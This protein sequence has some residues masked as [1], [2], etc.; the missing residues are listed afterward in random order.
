MSR[1]VCRM[2][3]ALFASA[4]PPEGKDGSNQQAMGVTLMAFLL[5]ADG[6]SEVGYP[7]GK[8]VPEVDG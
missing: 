4:A 3:M 2:L 7:S 1:D 5:N 8:M 6:E